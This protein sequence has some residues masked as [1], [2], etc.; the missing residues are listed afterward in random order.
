[1]AMITLVAAAALL[2]GGTDLSLHQA[3]STDVARCHDWALALGR[4]P[5]A[6]RP[7][8]LRQARGIDPAARTKE[9]W[10]AAIV[11]LRRSTAVRRE[12]DNGQPVP[13][14]KEQLEPP[15]YQADLIEFVAEYRDPAAIEPLMDVIGYH[16]GA[17]QA[18]AAFGDQAV[19]PLLHALSGAQNSFG[20]PK[21]LGALIALEY[22][23]AGPRPAAVSSANRERIS[24]ALLATLR[25][26][27][28]GLRILAIIRT[29]LT[30]RDPTLTGLLQ[31]CGR[32]EA[33][34]MARLAPTGVT[35]ARMSEIIN[36]QIAWWEARNRK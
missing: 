12:G 26:Q 36:Q 10:E 3:P 18:V 5:L 15:G 22:M 13:E 27:S 16:R 20:N 32:G 25:S 17:A 33:G 29:A 24:A 9:L 14:R 4:G 8:V 21:D 11:E 30:L 19:D 1:M 34:A 35:A 6:S 31:A 2:L 28:D 23:F 7:S